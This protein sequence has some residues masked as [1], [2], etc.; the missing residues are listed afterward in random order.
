VAPRTSQA[1][2]VH[3]LKCPGWAGR[4]GGGAVD[5]TQIKEQASKGEYAHKYLTS[6]AAVVSVDS[7]A[8]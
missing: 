3:D 2:R 4:G 8:S 5:T 1:V 7:V 6:R